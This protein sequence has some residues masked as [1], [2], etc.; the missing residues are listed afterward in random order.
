LFTLRRFSTAHLLVLA[1]FVAAGVAALPAL[2][3][4]AASDPDPTR[5]P[6]G[7]YFVIGCGVSRASHHHTF[8]G[9]RAATPRRSSVACCR[10]P[11]ASERMPTS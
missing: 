10:R 3:V 2:A 4:R 9:N 6:G 5:F 8:I 7:P 11:A 1:A